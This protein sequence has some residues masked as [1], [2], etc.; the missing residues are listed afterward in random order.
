MLRW[1][2]TAALLGALVL[3]AAAGCSGTPTTG[4]KG[5]SSTAPAST[6]GKPADN[7]KDTP[8]STGH[9]HDPG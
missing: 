5:G 3:S 1:L 2:P 9:P 4:N 7:G 8:K 6:S